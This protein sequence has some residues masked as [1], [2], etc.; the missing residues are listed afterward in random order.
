MIYLINMFN[1][2]AYFYSYSDFN[3][4]FKFRNTFK[5]N[6]NDSYSVIKSRNIESQNNYFS[7]ISSP[8]SA[9][10]ILYGQTFT[11]S[12]LSNRGVLDD[13]RK[14]VLKYC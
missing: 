4:C 5:K 3:F 13:L 6:A 8:E 10:N 2:Y 9:A 12:S 7:L 11:T 1:Q 14:L